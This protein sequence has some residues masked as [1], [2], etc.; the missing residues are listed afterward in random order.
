[1]KVNHWILFVSGAVSALL[2]STMYDTPLV[3]QT[4]RENDLP[5]LPAVT[6]TTNLPRLPQ[7][8]Q[9]DVPEVAQTLPERESV[10]TMSLSESSVNVYLMN[11]TSETIV[12]E[13]LGDIEPRTLA[14]GDTVALQALSVPATVT[15]F[16][17]AT[18]RDRQTGSGLTQAALTTEQE[19][20]L[21]KL[22][23]QPT[24]E[25]DSEVS[26][27]TVESNGNVFV[28]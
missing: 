7:N 2:A 5:Q 26:N 12:Y 25:L 1:M 13:A 20:S 16:Y 14:A 9:I 4:T 3:A 18:P 15:F 27:L 11:E 6:E 17:E 24:T 21:L 19:N 10:M 8:S 22:A 23:I 28:F